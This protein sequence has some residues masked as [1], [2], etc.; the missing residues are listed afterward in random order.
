VNWVALGVIVAVVGV[1]SL[2]SWKAGLTVAV[3]IALILV[4]NN[5]GTGRWFPGSI[6]DDWQGIYPRDDTRR[7]DD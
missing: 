4:M 1:I 5:T 2:I 6:G 3:L 7:G